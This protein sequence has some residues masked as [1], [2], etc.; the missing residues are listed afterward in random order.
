VSSLLEPASISVVE[1]EADLARVDPLELSSERASSEVAGHLS[2]MQVD[3]A[4]MRLERHG[5]IAGS[6]HEG[7]GTTWWMQLR[8]TAD[9]LRVLG[10]WPP[11][12]AAT[13][14]VALAQILRALGGSSLRADAGTRTPDP[15]LTMDGTCPC[16]RPIPPAKRD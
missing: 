12:E 15:L 6:R 1:G 3:D 10:E 8:P 9:G 7:S 14:N 16:G 5:L 4:L 11:V 2:H 13:I